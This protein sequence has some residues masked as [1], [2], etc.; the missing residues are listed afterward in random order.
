[1]LRRRLKLSEAPSEAHPL[2]DGN[3]GLTFSANEDKKEEGA[4][5]ECEQRSLPSFPNSGE[6]EARSKRRGRAN[7]RKQLVIPRTMALTQ[8]SLEAPLRGGPWRQL[9]PKPAHCVQR[10]GHHCT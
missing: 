10:L 7:G 6:N 4:Q 3:R 5:G 9:G 2:A 1:M 8:G